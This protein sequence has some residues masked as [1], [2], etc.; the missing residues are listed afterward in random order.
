LAESGEFIR[1]Y[2]DLGPGM[3]R[4]LNLLE[5]RNVAPVYI[6]RIL[7]AMPRS[8]TATAA[9]RR[10]RT[11]QDV[12]THE[13]EPLTLRELQVLEHLARRLTH[14]EYNNTLRDLA[15]TEHV[16]N[17]TAIFMEPDCG[18]RTCCSPAEIAYFEYTNVLASEGMRRLLRIATAVRRFA[19][20]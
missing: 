9:P 16:V 20:R 19:L 10:D 14:K 8:K 17:A 18:L 5:S 2:V 7:A 15:T 1:T 4:L 13:V 3:A 11:H 12:R 6:R